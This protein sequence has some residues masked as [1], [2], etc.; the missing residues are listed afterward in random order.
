M[1]V[2]VENNLEPTK[3]E[4]EVKSVEAEWQKIGFHRPLGGLLYNVV[5][6]FI[7]A[8]FGIVLTVWVIPNL[9]LPFPEALGYTTITTNLFSVYFTL[10]DL[11]IANAIQRFVA[12]E[13]IK[14]PKK[15]I[16]YMQFFIWYEMIGGGAEVTLT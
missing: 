14:N 12:E 7:A 2:M 10:M 11:G 3:P 8:G 4:T 13:N 16:Q 9:I 15:A 1:V 5:V 6:I